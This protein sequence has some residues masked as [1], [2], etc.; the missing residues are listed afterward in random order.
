[1]RRVSG[2]YVLILQDRLFFLADTTVNI[3]PTAEE[4]AEIA[5]LTVG[6]ARRFGIVPRVAMLSFSNFGSNN[7]PAARKVRRAVEIVTRLEPELEIDGEMQADTAVF[8]QILAGGLPLEPSEAAGQRPDL[9]RAAVGQRRLQADLA[10][11]RGGG[12]R[13][14]PAGDGEAGARPPER[15]RGERHR[16]HG[17]ALRG[18]R[19]GAPALKDGLEE[20]RFSRVKSGISGFP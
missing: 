15:R 11:G 9:P 2:A 4:L 18:R 1:M 12:D 13:P 20:E 8:E 10:P 16:E 7:H 19:A 3:D 17:G 6:F 14:D 5:L